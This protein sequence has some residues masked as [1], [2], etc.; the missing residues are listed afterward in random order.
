[1]E[2]EISQG[3]PVFS[4]LFLIYIKEVFFI[5]KKQLLNVTYMSFVNDFGFITTNSS[6]RKI[7]STLEKAR[8]IV[9]E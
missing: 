5:V 7:A 2:S 4:I 8:Q 1:M 9:P 3:L 6:I